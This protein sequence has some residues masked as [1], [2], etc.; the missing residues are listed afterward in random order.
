MDTLGNQIF[1]NTINTYKLRKKLTVHGDSL[2]IIG[3]MI[4]DYEEADGNTEIHIFDNNNGK[5]IETISMAYENSMASPIYISPD[6]KGEYDVY[7]LRLDRYASQLF[8]NSV[9]NTD[10]GTIC[11]YHTDDLRKLQVNK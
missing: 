11:I 3:E 7:L 2:I 8:S 4:T 6:L 5:H 9:I 1:D 10:E